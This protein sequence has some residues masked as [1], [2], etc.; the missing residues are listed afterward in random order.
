M[1]LTDQIALQKLKQPIGQADPTERDTALAGLKAAAPTQQPYK[2]AMRN[3]AEVEY[4]VKQLGLSP[5]LA[6]GGTSQRD[7]EQVY[8]PIHQYQQD[9][10]R[11]KVGSPVAVARLQNEGQLGAENIRAGASR[12][13]ASTAAKSRLD[14]AYVNREGAQRLQDSNPQGD[15]Y[16]ALAKTLGVNS[17][18]QGDRQINHVGPGGVTFGNDRPTSPALFGRL[19]A[20][21][22]AYQASQHWY[23]GNVGDPSLKA[24]MD[25]LEQL[26]GVAASGN[27][28]PDEDP[29]E[30]ENFASDIISDPAAGKLPWEQLQTRLPPELTP[31]QREHLRATLAKLRG[32]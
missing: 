6:N 28:Q 24:E 25:K 4:M 17:D 29:Q 3:Q 30:I 14:E 12:D 8:N 10:E 21:R 32:F 5:D 1:P 11:Q 9:I 19:D 22:K 16:R 15:Y 31:N 23:N 2:P 27:G 13:V 26:T 18:G 7:I 20:A